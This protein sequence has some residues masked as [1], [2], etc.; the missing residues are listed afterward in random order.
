MANPR[1]R[2]WFIFSQGLKVFKVI[3]ITLVNDVVAVA[4]YLCSERRSDRPPHPFP[5]G[6]GGRGG[7]NGGGGFQHVSG[8]NLSGDSSSAGCVFKFGHC[9]WDSG[10]C[11]YKQIVTW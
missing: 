7:G 5:S 6:G 11:H 2:L 3:R 10:I 8:R 1:A 4:L 9:I